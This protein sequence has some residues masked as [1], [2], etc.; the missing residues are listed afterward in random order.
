MGPA[1]MDLEEALQVLRTS[2]IRASRVRVVWTG[3]PPAV[4]RT[5]RGY[6]YRLR[7]ASGA[8][9]YVGLTNNVHRRLYL[10]LNGHAFKPWW[11]DVA[12]V[13]VDTFSDYDDA[14]EAE[15][16]AIATEAPVHNVKAEPRR[17]TYA[18]EP[19]ARNSAE[20]V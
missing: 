20:V 14:R 8:L 16:H 5:G 7:D 2:D 3:R 13:D 11:V 19:L 15:A 12:S 18:P 4:R 17:R 6:V 1:V 9:L 10:D